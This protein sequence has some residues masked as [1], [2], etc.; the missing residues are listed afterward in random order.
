MML[1]QQKISIIDLYMKMSEIS[2]IGDV[3]FV[4]NVEN[5]NKVKNIVVNNIEK[6]NEV[7]FPLFREL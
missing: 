7:Y 5:V 6:F 3:R 4:A 2:Y 1:K